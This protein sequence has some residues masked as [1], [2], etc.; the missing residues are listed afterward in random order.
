LESVI[1]HWW[2]KDRQ[3]EVFTGGTRTEI[4]WSKIK[5]WRL[6]GVR[7]TMNRG[8]CAKYSKGNWEHKLRCKGTWISRDGVSG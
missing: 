6:N 1:E 4:V 7:G 2:E 5:V 3:I 8:S